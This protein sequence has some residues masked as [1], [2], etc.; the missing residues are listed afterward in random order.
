V[1]RLSYFQEQLLHQ[2][3]VSVFVSCHGPKVEL[4]PSAIPGG[5]PQIVRLQVV[6]FEVD[7]SICCSCDFLK[8]LVLFVDISWILFTYWM[9]LWWMYAGEGLLVFILGRQ[10]MLE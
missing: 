8:G 6:Q 9:T 4:K 2:E 3:D 1:H 7:G 5:W 10:Y